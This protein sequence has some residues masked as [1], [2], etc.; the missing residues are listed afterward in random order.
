M[1]P[2]SARPGVLPLLF[3]V[4]LLV[5]GA[6]LVRELT[7]GRVRRST[8]P[9]TSG[10]VGRGA[11]STPPSVA[12]RGA[13]H[14]ME[15]MSGALMA[16]L[17]AG[18][19][20]T[21]AVVIALMVFYVRTLSPAQNG[22]A[23]TAQQTAAI[24]PP[25]PNLQATPLEDIDSLRHREEVLLD[26]YAW[27]DPAHTRARIPISRALTLVVGHSLDTAPPGEVPK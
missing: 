18:L 22:P 16:R 3:R 15:D 27:I 7:R 19:G 13:G 26:N 1:P 11:R 12:A 17:L 4:L 6:T 21:V 23:L 9:G 14:E 8:E 24:P 20:V 5:S 10:S 2:R 25:P